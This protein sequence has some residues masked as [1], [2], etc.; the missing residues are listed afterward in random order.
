[1][2]KSAMAGHPLGDKTSGAGS[3]HPTVRSIRLVSVR[4]IFTQVS[5]TRE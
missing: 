3:K 1:V 5:Q 4:H 2:L